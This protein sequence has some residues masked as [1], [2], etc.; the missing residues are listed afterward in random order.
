MAAELVPGP[1]CPEALDLRPFD[2]RYAGLVASWARG[3]LETYWLAPRTEPP[4]TA[5][6]VREWA[7]PAHRP[8]MLVAPGQ[9][10]PLGYGELNLLHGRRH[11]YW[12]G[13]LVVDPE[14]RGR[15]FGRQLTVLLL[16]RAF[17]QFGAWYVSLVV[18]PENVAA[19][20]CYRAAGM[21][22]DG[23][24]IHT[25]PAYGSRERLLRFIATS[26]PPAVA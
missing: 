9:P 19:V 23:F 15:G 25:F 17:H 2:P 24:E 22:E 16:Q 13:H 3:P 6:K 14:Q 11:E 1:G 7:D 10:T 20:A 12:L 4:L 5:R 21:R 26:P 18:F 8:Y